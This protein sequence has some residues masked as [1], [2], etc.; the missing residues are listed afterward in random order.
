MLLETLAKV[1]FICFNCL[2]ELLIFLF[3]IV[4]LLRRSGNGKFD[5]ESVLKG[6]N[7]YLESLINKGSLRVCEVSRLDKHTAVHNLQN[8]FDVRT[9]ASARTYGYRIYSR[10]NK[11]LNSKALTQ[12]VHDFISKYEADEESSKLRCADDKHGHIFGSD[13]A[14]DVPV[15][16]DIK[17]MQ[18]AAN[19]LIGIFCANV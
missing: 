19:F 9:M 1:I 18:L 14:W 3:Q 17:A 2:K 8:S 16:L 4:D 11:L 6:S 10:P 5:P 15:A 7:F 12:S 13:L